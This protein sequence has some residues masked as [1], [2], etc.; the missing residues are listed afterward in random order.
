MP[1]K[2]LIAAT[3]CLKQTYDMAFKAKNEET[4]S[5]FEKA[6]LEAQRE[7]IMFLELQMRFTF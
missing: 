1:I 6:D 7:H 2:P 4:M 3:A 5:L